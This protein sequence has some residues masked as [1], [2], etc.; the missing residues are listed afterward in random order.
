MHTEP[1]RPPNHDDGPLF[2]GTANRGR[3]VKIGDTVHRP[4]GPYSEAV[5]ALLS[6]LAARGFA[7][8]PAV[9]SRDDR[10]EILTY[11]P[12]TAANEP[13]PE[14]ALSDDALAS[15]AHL[16]RDYHRHAAAFRPS[17]LGWQ[18][19]I[20]AQW[21]GPLVTHNDVHPAN[22][23]FRNARAVA[24]IDFDLAAPGCA[25]WELAVAACF[26]VPLLDG[27]DVADSRRGRTVA[28]LRLLLDS[29][30]AGPELRRDV[31]TATTQA[32]EWISGII[33][34]AAAQG[35]PAFGKLWDQ[36]ADQYDRSREWLRIQH[37]ELARAIA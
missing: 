19:P 29:Y 12:G 3:V 34:D 17:P 27:R 25:A 16:I 31:L 14:W 22:V 26:W 9:V 1:E 30:E 21:Q 13:I 32:N 18:R 24:L 28:R 36:R 11:I 10:T 4:A 5:H 35:H 20:P 8:A 7:G 37:D 15:V 23:I 2:G 6:H 33:Q